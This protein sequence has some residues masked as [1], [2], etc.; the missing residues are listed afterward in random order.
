MT[1]LREF[2]ENRTN[3]IEKESKKADTVLHEK[4]E[5]ETQ[6]LTQC[7]E[8]LSEDLK[9]K[10]ELVIEDIDVVVRPMLGDWRNTGTVGGD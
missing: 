5:S 8:A 3:S 1:A 4:I 2:S 10:L 7:F 9:L 6:K